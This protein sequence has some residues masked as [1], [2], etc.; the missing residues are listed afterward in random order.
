MVLGVKD[1]GRGLNRDGEVQWEGKEST[2]E[3]ERK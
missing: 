3:T 1:L 2:L